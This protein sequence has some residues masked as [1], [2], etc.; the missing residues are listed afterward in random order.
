MPVCERGTREIGEIYTSPAFGRVITPVED[1]EH[2]ARIL[3]YVASGAGEPPKNIYEP[4]KM[5]QLIK[6]VALYINGLEN[7][8]QGVSDVRNA[9]SQIGSEYRLSEK[10]ISGARVMASC[11]NLCKELF[12]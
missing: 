7:P 10:V 6:S 9:I 12:F 5:A 8:R 11:P 4:V 3:I 2:A 1:T